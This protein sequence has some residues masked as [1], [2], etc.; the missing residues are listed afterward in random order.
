MVTGQLIQVCAG[1]DVCLSDGANI[2]SVDE[3]WRD[4]GVG[5]S[6]GAS[7]SRPANGAEATNLDLFGYSDA[8]PGEGADYF[9]V[10]SA[11]G[12]ALYVPLS[13]VMAVEGN[14]VSLTVDVGT[15]PGLQWDIQPDFVNVTSSTDSQAGSRIA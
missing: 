11:D 9:R 7:G 15:L 4:V 3:V 2:G 12:C 10:L 8:M 14:L 6:W 13:A 5:E 1:M